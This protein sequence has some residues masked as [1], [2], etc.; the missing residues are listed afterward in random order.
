VIVNAQ[1]TPLDDFADIV[2]REP[3]GETLRQL[4]RQLPG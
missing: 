1:P 3:I 4:L 2:I